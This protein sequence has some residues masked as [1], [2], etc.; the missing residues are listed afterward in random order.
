[1]ALHMLTVQNLSI[2]AE[3]QQLADKANIN[4]FKIMPGS[5]VTGT[6][7]KKSN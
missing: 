6:K 1:M 7:F 3:I 2:M 4:H 5:I